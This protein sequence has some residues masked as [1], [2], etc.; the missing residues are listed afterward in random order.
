MIEI[1]DGHIAVRGEDID[2][3]VKKYKDVLITLDRACSPEWIAKALGR[4]EKDV[5]RSLDRLNT[6]GFVDMVDGFWYR[7]A[8]GEGV[9]IDCKL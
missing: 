8:L 9:V 3:A 7:S 6:K 4:Q 5:L 1:R 2:D